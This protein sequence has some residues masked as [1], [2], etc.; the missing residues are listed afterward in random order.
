MNTPLPENST[1]HTEHAWSGRSMLVTGAAG[2]IGSH[3]VDQLLLRG[4]SVIG[5]DN[6]SRGLKRYLSAAF[7]N[8]NF[9]FFECDLNDLAAYRSILSGRQIATVWHMAANSDIASG[10]ADP[11]VDLRDTFQSTFHTLL[12]MREKKIPRIAFASSS[13]VYGPHSIT[14][15]ETTGPLLPIS[16]YGAMKLASEAIISAAVESFLEQAW[17]FRF[18]NV[19]GPRATHGIIYDLLNKLRS[20]PPDLEVLG[21]GNQQK[22]YLHVEELLEAML[23]IVE[24]AADPLS[25][26]NIGPDDEGTTVRQIAESVIHRASPSTPI[27]YTGGSKGWIGDVPRF[28]YSIEK[29][30]ALGW[31]PCLSS[32]GAIDKAVAQIYDEMNVRNVNLCNA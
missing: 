10:T 17:I 20:R 4:H 12:V 2:F 18:P 19:I 30:K 16:N 7:E 13:A 23:F 31:S 21:D 8:S 1:L 27:R 14:L 26:F 3:L 29:L 32:Q 25:C 11:Y 24:Q 22:P 28:Q 5:V 6:L 15:T 9:C